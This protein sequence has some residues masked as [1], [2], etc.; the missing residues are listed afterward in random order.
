M[1]GSNMKRLITSL[2]I[3]SMLISTP[4]LA[5]NYDRQ[6][7]REWRDRNE[8]RGNGCGWLCGAI[9]GGV[10]VGA[11]SSNNRDRERN[12][13]FDNRYYPPDYRIDRR[14]CVREQVTEWYRGE[15]YVYWQ[16]TCN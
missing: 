3:G 1:K 4:A 15:R 12:R 7:R 10:V 16:T 13:Q 8:R 2:V 5:Q 14:H 11:L 6:D 9:I